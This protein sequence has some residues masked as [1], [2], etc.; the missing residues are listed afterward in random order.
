MAWNSMR[1]AEVWMDDYKERFYETR[2][3]LRGKP[4]G[5]IS[6]RLDL[7]KKLNCHSFQW[8]LD[9]VYPEMNNKNGMWLPPKEKV[10]VKWKGKVLEQYLVAI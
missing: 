5:D 10:T 8:F 7:R 2:P 6:N 3:E 1:L 9:N 4:F